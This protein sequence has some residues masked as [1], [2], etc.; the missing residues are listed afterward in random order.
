M[1]S[2]IWLSRSCL[3]VALQYGVNVGQ[4]S[5]IGAMVKNHNLLDFVQIKIPRTP[6]FDCGMHSALNVRIS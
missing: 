6:L 4:Y 3:R 1:Y 2:V 5:S